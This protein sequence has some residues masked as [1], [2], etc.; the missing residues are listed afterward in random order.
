M[1]IYSLANCIKYEGK[2]FKTKF[3]FDSC[4]FKHHGNT[5]SVTQKYFHFKFYMKKFTTEA[6]LI[7]GGAGYALVPT[8]L[9]H[10]L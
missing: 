7:E 1:Y 3:I 6:S 2:H 8:F 10:L 9:K 5:Y 4:L